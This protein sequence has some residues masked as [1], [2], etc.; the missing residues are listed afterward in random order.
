MED[1]K[2]AV[3]IGTTGADQASEVPGA[4]ISTFDSAPLA[5]QELANGNVDAVIND[6]PVTL[7]E[8]LGLVPRH[9][10]TAAIRIQKSLKRSLR[11][12]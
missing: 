2:I 12:S 7:V 3:Q 4:E 8:S 9:Q 5:L 6:A 10:P 11:S 1:K